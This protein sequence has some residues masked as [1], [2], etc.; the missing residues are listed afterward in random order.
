MKKIKVPEKT[1]KMKAVIT[2]LFFFL[3]MS[4]SGQITR[5]DSIMHNGIFRQYIIHVPASY[6]AS[7]PHELVFVLHGGTGSALG[8]MLFTGFN[9]VSD[10]A[11][12]IVVYP[13]GIFTGPNLSGN[14]GHHWADGRMTTIPDVQGIDDVDFISNLIATISTE[15]NV[16]SDR[17]YA[18]GIS[19]GGF[20]VQRLACQLSDKITAVASVAATFPDSIRQSCLN[21]NPISILIMNGTNDNFVPTYTGGM[22]SGAGGYVLS[23][24]DMIDI[25]LN[26]NN[27]NLATDSIEL[28]NNST[29][30]QSTVSKFTYTDCSGLTCIFHYKIFGGGHTWPGEFFHVPSTGETNEDINANEEIWK[31]FNA[32][33]KDLSTP[34]S[35]FKEEFLINIF[36]NPFEDNFS[37]QFPKNLIHK[38]ELLDIQGK[39]VWFKSNINWEEENITINSQG[40]LKNGLYLVNC[41]STDQVLVKTV[42]VLKIK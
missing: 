25:W 23:T 12:F 35:G 10:T 14:P 13:Q 37:I 22:G 27:C 8:M 3:S 21:T 40:N 15:Y 29:T 32:K 4:L 42:K 38:I 30:D 26:N 2:V 1:P 28:P 41:Y 17:I 9:Q 31:F 39:V 24:D 36:P 11:N 19:N 5:P 20:M 34:I 33:S 18:A 6:N 7:T 16:D